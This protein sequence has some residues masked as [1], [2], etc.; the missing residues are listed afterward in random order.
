MAESGRLCHYCLCIDKELTP[1]CIC[2]GK[3]NSSVIFGESSF[4]ACV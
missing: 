2:I 1:F 3:D 4:D